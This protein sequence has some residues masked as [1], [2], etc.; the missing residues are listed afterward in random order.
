MSSVPRAP[1]RSGPSAA[2]RRRPILPIAAL[3]DAVLRRL[4][5]SVGKNPISA[6]E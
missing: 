6:S 5:Y 3:R 1:L 2:G 4:T